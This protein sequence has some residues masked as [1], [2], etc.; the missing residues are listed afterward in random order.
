MRAD[1]PGPTVDFLARHRTGRAVE[2][3][4]CVVILPPTYDARAMVLVRPAAFDIL[5]TQP[6]GPLGQTDLA[7][8]LDRLL[9]ATGADAAERGL[10]VGQRVRLLDRKLRG[11]DDEPAQAPNSLSQKIIGLAVGCCSSRSS[12]VS[13]DRRPGTW[14]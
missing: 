8:N 12:Q 7:G 10:V 13:S 1:R 5:G 6:S 2:V 3:S 4:G 14:W 11:G 9:I